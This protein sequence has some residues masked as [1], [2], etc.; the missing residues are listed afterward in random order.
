MSSQAGLRERKKD[1]TRRRIATTAIGLF[2]ER[3]FEAV[4]VADVAAAADVSKM[5]VFNYFPAKEDLFFGAGA[6]IYPDLADAVRDREPE[7]NPIEA[8]REFVRSELQRRAEWTGLHDGVAPFARMLL[9]SPALTTALE[10]RMS[11]MRENLV[12]AL[13]EAAGFSPAHHTG[14]WVE[15]ALRSDA[16]GGASSSDEPDLGELTAD[17]LIPRMVAE[18]TFAVIQ[19]LM[20][21]NLLRQVAGINA[22]ASAS[23]ALRTLDIGFDLLAGGLA[24][25]PAISFPAKSAD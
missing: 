17:R 9:G 23:E 16:A 4:S 24:D 11:A 25:F 14:D 18:Q 5:T 21:A 20:M 7:T 8:I 2:L 6:T 1:Q 10:G 12:A 22:D 15:Q 13:E 3:G 19:T